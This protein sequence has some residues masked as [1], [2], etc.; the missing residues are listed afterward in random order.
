MRATPAEAGASFPAEVAG[1]IAAT[2]R[3]SPDPAS[4]GTYLVTGHDDEHDRDIVLGHICPV[5]IGAWGVLIPGTAPRPGRRY[6]TRQEATAAT[7][8][9][10]AQTITARRRKPRH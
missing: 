3:F 2:A 7:R 6:A 4:P 9:R 5:S 10:L 1:K 8:Y